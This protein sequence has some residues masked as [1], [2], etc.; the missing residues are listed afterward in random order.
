MVPESLNAW[1]SQA[2]PKYLSKIVQVSPQFLAS[3][4][5]PLNQHNQP[6][7]LNRTLTGIPPFGCPVT[8]PT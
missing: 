8:F 2:Y 4:P 5:T 6:Y 1:Y 7:A 3:L